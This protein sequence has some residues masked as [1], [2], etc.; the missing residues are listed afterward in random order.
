MSSAA[1]S[2]GVDNPKAAK[3]TEGK[4]SGLDAAVKVL[5]EAGQ[6]MK[7][8][9]MVEQMLAKGYWQ[10][11]GATPASTLYAAVIREI[12]DKREQSRFRK[13]DRGFFELNQ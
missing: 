5:T 7:C 10:T 6:P 1:A 13:V 2:L 9:D 11:N 4:L 8:G 3:T 12:R